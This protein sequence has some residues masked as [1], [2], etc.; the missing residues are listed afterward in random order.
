MLIVFLF[1]HSWRTTVI[2]GLTL[3]IAVIAHL[4]RGL[5]VR[6]HAQ[7]HD[8]DGAV[9]VRRPADRRRDRGAREHRAPRAHGQGPPTAARDGTDEIGLA[10]LATTF[11]IVAVFVP[12]AFMGGIIGKF[13]HQFGI[14]VAVA[15][16]ISLFVS[17]TLDPM[18]SSIWHDPPGSRFAR[19]P[20]SAASW[21]GSSTASSGCTRV[22]GDCS[23]G[24]SHI[25]RPCSRSPRRASS[26]ASRSCRWSAPS[27]SPTRT[28]ASS[29][30]GST[31]RSARA[32]STPTARCA[33]SSR[34]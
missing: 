27:S 34:C 20:C 14:T 11:S 32:S 16:L 12:V 13:F 31:R 5:R 3:P 25:A 9:A 18:L 23:R 29:R 15:V 28:R 2:T 19:V 17:F 22:Y 10:V 7:L 6:L 26:P 33:R 4:H 30:C 1:L 8:A 24:R 21:T